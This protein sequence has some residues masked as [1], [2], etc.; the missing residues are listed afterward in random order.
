MI[1][2]I[3]YILHKYYIS[4]NDEHYIIVQRYIISEIYINL[5]H[6]AKKKPICHLLGYRANI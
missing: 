5:V 4:K 6:T 2:D 1:N 3:I